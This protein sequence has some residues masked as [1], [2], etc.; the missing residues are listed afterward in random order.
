MCFRIVI[1]II[2]IIHFKIIS[3]VYSLFR[4]FLEFVVLA[5]STLLLPSFPPLSLSLLSSLLSSLSLLL[6][7]SAATAGGVAHNGSFCKTS[8][9]LRNRKKT[10]YL[11]VYP[12][13]WLPI[14]MHPQCLTV[15][16]CCPKKKKVTAE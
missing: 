8:G 5:T 2:I 16:S 14:I 10:R 1:I 4:F 12:R 7:D 3:R 11:N 15:V 6:F 13:R 9:C